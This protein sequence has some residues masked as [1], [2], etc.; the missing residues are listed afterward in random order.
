MKPYTLRKRMAVGLGLCATAALLFACA[1]DDTDRETDTES[2]A[3]TQTE[4]TGESAGGTAGETDASA[5]AN[6][7]VSLSDPMG[8]PMSNIIFKVQQ[9]GEDVVMKMIG[10]SGTAQLSLPAGEYTVVLES[11][12]GARLYYDTDPLTVAPNTPDTEHSL[13][14]WRGASDT[15]TFHAPSL[16]STGGEYVELTA[17]LVG[18]GSTYIEFSENDYTYVVFNPTRAG[19]FEFTVPAGVEVAYHGMPILVYDAPRVNADE[20]GVVSLPVEATSLGGDG[21]SQMVFR[22]TPTD[23]YT[24]GGAPFTV[25]R[26]GDIIKTPEEQ[27]SWVTYQA[28]SDMLAALATF[29][30]PTEGDQWATLTEGT[31]TNLDLS[32]PNLAVVL[33][34]DGYYHLGTADGPM[35][36]VRITSDSPYIEDF[37][38]MCETDH[39]RAFFYDEN[40]T[41]LRKEGYNSFINAYA[42]VVN[43][44]G[45]VPLNEE[46]AYVIQNV[47][48]HM[49]WWNFDLG[50]D[51]FEDK[52]YP[53]SVAWLFACA[54][55]QA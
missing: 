49:G 53:T 52:V 20:N 45:V 26:T 46:L 37:A 12:D 21:I 32:D 47:G 27:A 2:A 16:M 22:L 15:W 11:P 40:G 30:D 9:D 4:S 5:V 24:D 44:D 19:V 50:T 33:G 29:A 25:T 35:V 41:F 55:Y 51:I 31:L 48:R 54:T 3:D 43:A 36:F 28:D 1:P 7:T 13:T 10:E 6:I 38:K 14:V 34:E 39:L 18:E 23:A 17:P 8:N 42:E